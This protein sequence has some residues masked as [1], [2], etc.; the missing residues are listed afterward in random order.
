MNRTEK[1]LTLIDRLGVASV[2]QLHEI[3]RL[4][5]YR[6]TCR[7]INKLSPYL[8]EVRG[9]EKVVYLNK[10]GRELIASDKEVKKSILF[11]HMLL[12]ND[13]YIYF[14]CPH[15]WQ[16]EHVIESH[17]E[18]THSF[19]IQVKGLTSTQTKKV[20]ADATFSRNGYLYLIEIDNTRHMT[21]NMKK[22][23]KYKDM[24]TDIQSKHKKQPFLYFITTSENRKRKLLSACKGIRAEVLTFEEIR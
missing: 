18:A 9:R 17:T 22:I 13:A 12:A 11:D 20:V 21:D 14:S 5:T 6:N 7:V 8:H 10:D 4:G 16:T 3:L 1:I 23:K 2:R 15:D 19:A 24:W